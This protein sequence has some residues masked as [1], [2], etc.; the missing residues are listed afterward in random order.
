MESMQDEESVDNGNGPLSEAPLDE[1]LEETAEI[2]GQ[3]CQIQKN[4]VSGYYFYLI[5]QGNNLEEK[6]LNKLPLK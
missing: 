6:L 3:V 4:Q 5:R 2:P 1:G